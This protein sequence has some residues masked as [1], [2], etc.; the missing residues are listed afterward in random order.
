MDQQ[1]MK[2]QRITI[3][4]GGSRGDVQPYVAL[5]LALKE[6]G[7]TVRFATT[8][9]FRDLVESSFGFGFCPLFPDA[10]QMLQDNPKI[11]HAM[12]N[13]KALTL[14]S[15]MAAANAKL[16]PQAVEAF[17]AE[18]RDHPPDLIIKGA[19]CDFL[20]FTAAL[21]LNI[22]FVDLFWVLISHNPDR[23]VFGFP[24]LPFGLHRIFPWVLLSGYY[25][26]Q[27]VYDI[28]G[29]VTKKYCKSQF[30]QSHDQSSTSAYPRIMMVSSLVKPILYPQLRNKTNVKFVGYATVPSQAQTERTTTESSS[31]FGSSQVQ[32]QL[33]AFLEA[34]DDKEDC[35]YLGW[36]SM[37]SRSPHYM[38]EFAVRTLQ[39]VGKR[40][41]ILQGYA[42]LGMEH[43]HD[44][45]LLE[46]ARAN[47][48]FVPKAPH[49]WLFQRVAVTVHH[50]GSGTT[51]AAL[52]SGKPTIVTPVFLDQW[53][54]AYLVNQV[55]CG[56][57]FEQTQLQSLSSE[58]LA[59]AIRQVLGSSEE[60]STTTQTRRT[61]YQ[62]RAYDVAEIVRKENGAQ[63]AVVE[64]EAFWKEHVVSGNFSAVFP[65]TKPEGG[66]WRWQQ[67]AAMGVAVT[68]VGLAAAVHRKSRR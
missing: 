52:R 27:K 19:M 53:D 32:E 61:M 46:Y 41:I 60:S 31:A 30:L 26:G 17:E 4:A 1:T 68:A 24:K 8:A 49:E 6:K 50:G 59:A 56:Y 67:L 7:Y 55:G 36:G 65:G 35:I 44:E 18:M 57:G 58:D 38:T 64:L 9:N 62:L 48:L 22:P 14:F 39:L 45:A 3:V 2:L 16:A 10:N 40:G 13:G 33:E 20:V 15:G 37:G 12:Q 63:Q 25:E 42:G 43:I 54:H 5:A 29:V 11:Q 28:E 34:S 21:K 23:P 47:V 51:A 66:W